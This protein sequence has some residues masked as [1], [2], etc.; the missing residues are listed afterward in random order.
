MGCVGEAYHIGRLALGD[1]G[2]EFRI[3]GLPRYHVGRLALDED[4]VHDRWR[5][6]CETVKARYWPWLSGKSLKPGQVV[7][8][9]LGS[10]GG[11]T[12]S[13]DWP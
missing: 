11:P 4:P 12:T 3:S 7:P 2:F 9:L 6:T 13:G 10:G 8:S 1:S 5:G